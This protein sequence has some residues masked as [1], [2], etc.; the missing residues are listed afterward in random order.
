MHVVNFALAEMLR[1]I[2]NAFPEEAR[3]RAFLV[4]LGE[5]RHILSCQAKA[6]GVSLECLIEHS[7]TALSAQ[8][9]HHPTRVARN[10]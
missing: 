5:A 9:A 6:L 7:F 8:E 1:M 10:L 4:L 3:F 2:A